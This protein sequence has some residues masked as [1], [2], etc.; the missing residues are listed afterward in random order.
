M[1]FV[2]DCLLLWVG[3]LETML[4]DLSFFSLSHVINPGVQNLVLISGSFLAEGREMLVVIG[5]F[6]LQGEESH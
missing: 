1:G 5:V 3:F 4:V 6:H 2:V